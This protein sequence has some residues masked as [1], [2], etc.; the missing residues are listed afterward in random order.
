MPL[1]DSVMPKLTP[2]HTRT[3]LR[4][5]SATASIL[6][7]CIAIASDN[8]TPETAPKLPPAQWARSRN[9]DVKHIALNLRFDWAKKQAIGSATITLTPFTATDR[10]TLDAGMLSIHA[11]KNAQ[12][13]PLTFDYDGSDRNDALAIHLDRTY[14][15]GETLSIEISYRSNW[16][17]ASDPNNL[18]GS[19]G[20]GV[21]YF[22]P[23]QTEPKKRRQIWVNGEADGNRYWFPSF[24]GANDLRTSELT[25]TVDAPLIAIANGKLVSV[26]DHADG[27]RSFHWRVDQAIANSRTNLVI[28]E[29]VDV[30]QQWGD[31][32]LH[33]F[34][35]PDEQEAVIASTAR[36][37]DMTQFYTNLT[38]APLLFGSYAQAFV[39]DLPWGIAGAALATHSENMIDDAGTHDDYLYLWDGLQ[40]ESLASQWFGNALSPRDWSESW[41][42]RGFAHYFSGLYNEH[43][44]GR[45][46]FLLWQMQADKN[47][48][49]ADWNGGIRLPVVTRHFEDATGFV[50]S[51]APYARAGLVLHM[52]R[53]QLGEAKWQ[54]SIRA[55]VAQNSGQLVSTSDFSDAV[56]AATGESLD[57]FFDQWLY[58]IGHPVF[59]VSQHFDAGQKQLVLSVKQTQVVDAKSLYP[60]VEFFQGKVE[61]E[62]DGRI[63]SAWLKPQAENVLHF[64]QPLPACLEL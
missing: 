44:N 24:D 29:Y 61:I 62:I 35:Y 25:V 40:A 47:T 36:L 15:S 48:Y 53:K 13:K 3:W 51:N 58:K 17:N 23:T 4:A 1:K 7:C 12:G 18:W 10:I 60:Q 31:V 30:K 59:V 27:T 52:L 9:I 8:A 63:E 20:K 37:A 22:A 32:T 11:I 28:G 21:R 14:Q 50:S 56:E 42:G 39:Q 19:V 54:A 41:L 5:L 33:S 2:P 57:W 43:K 45:A 34:G 49:L 6:F 55:Y 26:Q 64:A 46:E 38:G 16:V